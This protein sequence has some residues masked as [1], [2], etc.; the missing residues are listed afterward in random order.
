[1]L[2]LCILLHLGIITHPANWSWGMHWRVLGIFGRELGR[3]FSL[4]VFTSFKLLVF[5]LL[6][7]ILRQYATEEE[8]LT[9][10]RH[11]EAEEFGKAEE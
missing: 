3:G 5:P 10:I 4:P 2:L 7:N 1:M 11:H 6:L 9:S 8:K